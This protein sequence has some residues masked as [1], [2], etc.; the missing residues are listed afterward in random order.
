MYYISIWTFRPEH[1]TAIVARFLE[2]GGKP[3]DGVR[4]LSRWHDL[5]GSRGFAVSET[6]DPTLIAK[7]CRD[8]ADLLT[9]EIVPVIDDEQL[10]SVLSPG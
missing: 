8:W 5:G 3:P 10:A 2:T 7:W 6:D 4:M 1:R 9:F